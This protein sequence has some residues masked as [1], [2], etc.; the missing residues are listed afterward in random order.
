[1]IVNQWVPAA[2][3][4][5]AIGD[6]A[7]RVRDLLR[8]MGH[9]SEL[10]ALTVDDELRHD[11]RPFADPGARRGDLTI[12]HY[13][14]PSPMTAAFA[15]LDAGR[16]LQYHN[17]T[18]ASYFAPYDPALFRLATLGRE[19]LATLAGRTDLAL[20]DSEFNRQELAALGFERTGVFPIAVDTAR[21]TRGAPRPLLDEI[22]DD[23][24]VNFL[25]VG[26]IAPN[27]KIEDIIKLAEVYKRYID[28][29]YRFIFVGRYDVVP[30][31]YSM[32]RALMAE[33]RLLNDRFIFTGPVP[34]E[35]LGVYYRRS[36]V[37]LSLSEHE[38]F[39]V[40]L[41]EA[42]A[43]DLPVLAYSAAAVPDTLDGAGVQFAPK[44][45]EYAAELLGA[46]AFDDDLRARVIAGQRRRLA[47]FGDARIAREL[48]S[49]I[50]QLS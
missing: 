24:L 35:E 48:T 11:V 23:G 3:K 33:Y 6:S 20:G 46:L 39:C 10:Y 7:R 26:R 41:V 45:L 27:K 16:V 32:I 28:A 12:F 43:A 31:Y 1:V 15:S 4:G 36:A 25:F 13:A 40:P 21:V 44:D 18:P 14:L 34:D 38:G 47:D 22:L 19:E 17:V 2:H 49:L 42:M 5:D 9:D 37:Y 30:R 50:Q 8:R 29:Y